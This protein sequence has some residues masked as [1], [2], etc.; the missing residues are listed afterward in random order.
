[1]LLWT[2]TECPEAFTTRDKQLKRARRNFGL[3]VKAAG[4]G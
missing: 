4:R 3:A 1:M 2:V